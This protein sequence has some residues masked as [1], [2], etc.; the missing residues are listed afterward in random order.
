MVSV[1]SRGSHAVPRYFLDLTN[2]G[3]RF[4]DDEETDLENDAARPDAV[5]VLGQSAR[6]KLPNAAPP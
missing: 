2:N 4:P 3:T 1:A 6:D 5:S